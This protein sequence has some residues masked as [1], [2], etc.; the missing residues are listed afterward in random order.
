M[1][2]NSYF[3]LPCQFRAWD[4]NKAAPGLGEH[5]TVFVFALIGHLRSL[6]GLLKT[7]QNVKARVVYVES[8]CELQPQGDLDGFLGAPI[9]DAV[10][11]L[12]YCWDNVSRRQKTRRLYRCEVWHE[13]LEKRNYPRDR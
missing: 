1:R 5:E 4:M 7:I 8:H 9:F 13:T 6:R 12:G 3:A 2:L 11:F 10:E